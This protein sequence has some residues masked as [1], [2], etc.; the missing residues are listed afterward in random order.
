MK[1]TQTIL[2]ILVTIIVAGTSVYGV[3][4]ISWEEGLYVLQNELLRAE[5]KTTELYRLTYKPTGQE[6]M[7]PSYHG[8]VYISSSARHGEERRYLIQDSFKSNRAYEIEAGETEATLTVNFDWGWAPEQPDRPY[9]VKEQITI[10]ADKP[11]LRVRY[12]ISVKEK[13]IPVP[14]GLSV[15]CRG[16]RATHL[17]E[18]DGQLRVEKLG[19]ARM[20]GMRTDPS[21]YWFAY[22][23]E[24]SGH[25]TSV[26]RPGQTNPTRCVFTETNCSITGW[27]GLFLDE[28]GQSHSEE[29][30]LVAGQSDED[31]PAQIAQSAEEAY[32]FIGER[33][34]ILATLAAPYVTHQEIVEQTAHLRADGKGNHIVF[35]NERLY[36]DGKPFLLFA[37]WAA[38]YAALCRKYHLTG[39]F[40]GPGNLE[41]AAENDMMYVTHALEW[42]RYRG[43][44][45]E[46]HINSIKDHPALLAWF[47]ADDFSGDLKMLENIEIIRKCETHIPTIVDTVGYDAGRRRSSAFVDI[48]APYQYPVARKHTYRWYADY[49]DHNQ[50]I[51]DRQF[52]WTCPETFK[53]TAA[54][55]RLETYIGLA[56]GIRGFMYWAG[57]ALLD[58]RL[59]EVGIVCLAVEPLTELI[60]EA[61]KVPGGAAT[62]N[63]QIEV[64]RLD[65]GDHT[66]LFLVNY[67]DK[68]VRW[69]TG[70]LTPKFVV[71]V[72]GVHNVRAYSMTFDK[73][74]KIGPARQSRKDLQFQVSGLDIGAMVLLTADAQ[75]AQQ[76]QQQLEARRAEATEFA[77]TANSYMAWK[78]YELLF[79]LGQLKAPMGQAPQLYAQALGQ[80][81]A[82]QSF[83]GQRQAARLLRQSL[84]EA[85]AQADALADYAPAYAASNL[86][87]YY[88]YLPQFMASFNFRALKSQS[89]P[90]LTAPRYIAPMAPLEDAPEPQ[91]LEVGEVVAGSRKGESFE[92]FVTPLQAQ[93]AYGIFQTESGRLSLYPDEAS[94]VKGQTAERAPLGFHEYVELP[95]DNAALRAFLCRPD[96]DMDLYI[97]VQQQHTALGVVS[98]QPLS[99]G[100]VVSGPQLSLQQPIAMY[101]V[102]GSRQNS[103]AVSIEPTSG[104]TVEA[105][106]CQVHR[107]GAQV[108]ASKQI[109]GGQS[110]TLRCTLPDEGPLV[111]VV[112]PYAGSGEFTVSAEPIAEE[113]VPQLMVSPFVGVKF[114]FYGKE[115]VAFTPHLAAGGIS[116]DKLD[117]RLATADLSQY[118]VIILLTNAIKYDEAGELKAN[119]EKLKQFVYD[120]GGLVLFQQNGWDKWDDSILPYDMELLTSARRYEPPVMDEPNL[121]GDFALTEIAGEERTVGFYAIKLDAATSEEWQVLAYS[122]ES[123]NEALA[124]A[125]QY[126]EGSIIVNQFAIL[127]RIREPVMRSMMVETVRHVVPGN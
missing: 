30:W 119:A 7:S 49:L 64:Q 59:A 33:E 85:L 116:G 72:N 93:A 61:E 114:A 81:E 22:W 3:P 90:Q 1:T 100:E 9:A 28:P 99:L 46:T 126:G 110:Q 79:K 21:S 118:D 66:L 62:D 48:Q 103:F 40:G 122:G 80:I 74:L 18:P 70:E 95:G 89:P 105:R 60:V 108:L 113:V 47:L 71:T 14:V 82:A 34:P 73:D 44:E 13:P 63:E 36:V 120:G 91:P 123:D 43:E 2:W 55:I 117:G 52:N 68:S 77:T 27:S 25:F 45:L 37:P 31:L 86:E 96:A 17:V 102:T 50:K 8:V 56:H 94:Y 39:L 109:S 42:P 107:R 32:E 26:L 5:V 65:W 69:P 104:F 23:D 111:V 15:G 20:S 57:N 19:D 29:L 4:Q 11:Y 98:A 54:K 92:R 121:L 115:P 53:M 41:M 6:L 83:T 76:L 78:V 88:D 51:M 127:D 106:L 12:Y 35:K 58:H 38:K 84:A 75:Y 10:F 97:T 112:T 124:A 16:M 24:P 67:R 101:E 125:C 87:Q